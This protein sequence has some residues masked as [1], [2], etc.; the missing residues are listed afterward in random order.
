MAKQRGAVTPGDPARGPRAVSNPSIT[1]RRYADLLQRAV[2]EHVMTGQDAALRYA[3][4]RRRL[5]R[6]LRPPRRARRA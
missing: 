1:S 6:P 3:A 2:E 5:N 4:I